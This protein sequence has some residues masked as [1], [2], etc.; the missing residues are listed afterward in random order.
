[1]TK[2]LR[3]FAVTLC[4]LFALSITAQTPL[5]ES[6]YGDLIIT[7]LD[8]NKEK[9]NLE[10]SDYSD[11]VLL[12]ET[13][14]RSTDINH[15]YVN[16][17]YQNIRI[18]NAISSI[19][20]K[21][22][23]VFYFANRF[24]GNV[25]DKV[26]AIT[27]VISPEAA[28]QKVANQFELG[29]IN[30]LEQ[31]NVNGKRFTF[32]SA[33]ISS[34]D[35]P[36]ELVL[37]P[38]E[39]TL[40]LAWDILIF[41][42]DNSNWWSVRVDALSGDVLESNDLILSC[43]F[44]HKV[45][46]DNHDHATDF[47]LDLFK[48]EYTSMPAMVDGSRYNVFP[49][50]VES[51]NHGSRQIVSSPSDP[52]ASPFGWHDTD[53][54]L[55]P[56]HTI[57]RGNNVLAK[58]DVDGGNEQGGV[59]Y[60]PDGSQALV[61]DFPLDFSLSPF[62]Y[63]DAAITNLFYMNNMMHDVWYKHGFDEQSGNFQ[64]SNYITGQGIGN[65]FVFA[66]AQDGSGFN[67]ANFG[68]PPDGSNPRMQMFLWTP[69]GGGNSGDRLDVL[70][71]PLSG[72]YEAVGAT[73]G[74]DLP[75]DTA[76]TG[77]LG[78]ALDST[79][80]FYDAC[81]NLISPF[82]INGKIAVIRRGGCQFGTKVLAAENA[83][84]IAAIVVNNSPDALIPMGPGNDGGSV[85]IP[86]VM[87]T[88]AFGEQ[89]ISALENSQT[90]NISL[91]GPDLVGFVDG[92][93]DNVIVAHEYGHGISNRLAGGPQAA[94]CL[95][96]D[97]QM[98]EGWSDWFGLVI[99][100]TENDLPETGRGVGTFALSQPTTGGGIRPARYSTDFAVNPATYDDSN[101]LAQP[102]GIG[103]VW[104]TVLWD[105][106]WAYIDKYGFDSDLYNGSGGNNRIMQLVI[107]G[108][109]LQPCQPG[110][111]DGRDALL[112]ADM[113]TTGGENQCIIWEV[114]AA[115]GLGFNAQQGS[116]LN[117]G[118][119]VED[120]TLPPTD[121]PSLANCSSLNVDEFAQQNVSVYP[122][123]TQTELFIEAKENLGDVTITLIDINGRLVYKGSDSLFN[124]ISI[125]TSDLKAGLYILT[126]TGD[127]FS[128]NEKII[129]N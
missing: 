61:F 117:R 25:N 101:F 88:Q 95:F 10:E 99:T 27:P 83:G 68:T 14:S 75:T 65:D 86:S 22:A 58:E 36:V 47:K 38:K 32:N 13:Y 34:E 19:A 98:G 107:D 37:L 59:G 127:N 39:N 33:G 89:L 122:N 72:N 126:I 67:N 104:A 5:Q 109:K 108:L 84:A 96:N 116:S 119:Q 110:F 118:D 7:F 125:N 28:I 4:A 16:Q 53:G 52:V 24:I 112:A 79:A 11:L 97:E 76:I 26:N 92:D 111:I 93:F 23:K 114:F 15:Y 8:T 3:F 57:T 21:E 1:M 124:P 12:N 66:D 128:Y 90:I 60:S 94:N 85:T 64:E 74:A 30:A 49:L 71:G 87:V 120:F 40:Q 78:L 44:D 55:G 17:S 129:K 103:F 41:K 29:Q 9:Y 80:D 48:Q 31:L 102:H 106:T 35:I 63:Q 56:E 121:D 113:A 18:F 105:L 73:F 70:N 42:T 62:D 123:P 20:I 69:P 82:L 54:I 115:R 43:N 81:Q 51:P 91:Q 46:E 100:M 50:P 6:Q 2:T 45:S 77:Q